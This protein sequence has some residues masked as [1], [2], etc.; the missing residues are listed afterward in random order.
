MR[1]WL[2]GLVGAS[3]LT[4]IGLN[5]CPPGRVKSVARLLCGLVCALA[6][7]KPLAGL[8]P[9][10]L[11]TGMAVYRRQAQEVTETAQEEADRMKRTYIQD[12]CAAYIS[13]EAESL[14]LTAEASVTAAWDAQEEVWVPFEVTVNAPYSAALS[15]RIE[16][17]LGVPRERQVWS[18]DE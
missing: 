2:L 10:S 5:L 15:Y 17:D 1:Q 8:E 12:E 13:S 11:S 16:A 4:C 3:L 7:V 18:G 6:L 9:D 14:G